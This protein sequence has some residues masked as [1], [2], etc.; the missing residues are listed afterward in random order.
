RFCKAKAIGSNPLAGF[1]PSRK[2]AFSIIGRSS[3]SPL[4]ASML[5]PG[6]LTPICN[7]RHG[8]AVLT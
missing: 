1:P 2:R 4:G 3:H 8:M 5:A 7:H 6:Q